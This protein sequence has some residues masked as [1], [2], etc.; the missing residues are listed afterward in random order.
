MIRYGLMMVIV[1]S[2]VF[3]YGQPL[4][5]I[6]RRLK[7]L[8]NPT[9]FKHDASEFSTLPKVDYHCD[10]KNQ[11]ASD[12]YHVVD[13]NADGLKDLIYSGP[14]S[15]YNQT[16]IF[17]NTGRS[18]KKIY[19]YAGKI[20]S[21]EKN[22]SS[23]IVN[24]LKEA[25][26]CEFYSQFIQVTINDKSQFTKNTIVFGAKTKITLASKLREE[27]VVGTL[28]T[29]P[30]VNDVIKRDECNNAV[31]RGNQL[32]RIH[33]FENVIQLNKSG[34]WWLVLYQETSE[35]SWIGWMRLN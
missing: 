20:V 28:R 6:S 10:N 11:N 8:E 26:C 24:I 3:S 5:D 12:F 22:S 9:D 2:A 32:K 13:L 21:I 30:Q 16:A 14:C 7:V 1:A 33:D 25:C 4:A 18:L 31:I 19:D 17:V 29:T 27:K 35:R 15:P 34:P 23:T